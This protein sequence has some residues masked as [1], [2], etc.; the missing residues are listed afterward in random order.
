[1]AEMISTEEVKKRALALLGHAQASE[2]RARETK[3][4]LDKE[5]IDLVRRKDLYEAIIEH[6]AE[7]AAY[8]Y[9]YEILTGDLF[10]E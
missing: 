4:L 5:T 1:M 2:R 8:R 10:N 6:N 3:V 7:A 9:A